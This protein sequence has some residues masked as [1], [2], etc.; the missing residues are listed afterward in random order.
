MNEGKKNE[1]NLR[2]DGEIDGRETD[3]YTETY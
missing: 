2:R 3:E 1:N